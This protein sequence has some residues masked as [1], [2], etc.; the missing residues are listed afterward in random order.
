MFQK[1]FMGR[2][3]ICRVGTQPSLPWGVWTD[4]SKGEWG[5]FVKRYATLSGILF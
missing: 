4:E 3:I 5:H 2:Q 1:E